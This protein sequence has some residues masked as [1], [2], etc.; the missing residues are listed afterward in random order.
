MSHE[1][2]KEIQSITQGERKELL[3]LIRD[4]K[5]GENTD[6]S[7]VTKIVFFS[8]NTTGGFLTKKDD[9]A[10]DPPA[11]VAGT[12]KVKVPINKDESPSM[13]PDSRATVFLSLDFPLP[14]GRQILKID[15]AFEVI[16][17][18]FEVT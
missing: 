9:D 12:S 1:D 15:D 17:A 5:T 3:F 18:K 10:V 8:D 14:K 4:G 2:C 13:L 7:G 6:L 16:E 11:V